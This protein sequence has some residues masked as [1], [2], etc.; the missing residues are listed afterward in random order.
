MRLHYECRQVIMP[1]V[2]SGRLRETELIIGT[3]YLYLQV[4][5]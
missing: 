4:I 1:C 2:K 5:F 3:Q